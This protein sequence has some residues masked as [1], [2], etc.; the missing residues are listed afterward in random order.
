MFLLGT[1]LSAQINLKVSKA[2]YDVQGVPNSYGVYPVKLS[3]TSSASA[4][5]YGIYRSEENQNNFVFLKEL[6][7]SEKTFTDINP[8]AKPE[9]K[10]F[11]K[12]ISYNSQNRE[13]AIE[14]SSAESGWGA[15]TQEAYFLSFDKIVRSSHKRLTLMNKKHNLD[16]LGKEQI[17][18]LKSGTLSYKTTLKVNGLSG[19]VEMHYENY[20]DNSLWIFTGD[21]NTLANVSGDGSMSGTVTVKGMYPGTVTYDNVIIKNSK[22]GGGTYGIHSEGSVKKELDYTLTLKNE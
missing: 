13:N 5:Y 8:D 15:L 22:A 20:S 16:K 1:V 10:Y 2:S 21:M 19:F 3:W 17:N 11:Y 9:I 14:T 7:F 12:I 6:S 18:G 4:K